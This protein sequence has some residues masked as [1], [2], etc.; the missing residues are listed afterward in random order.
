[1]DKTQFVYAIYSFQLKH[2]T[3]VSEF[4]GARTVAIL[5]MIRVHLTLNC[6]LQSNK[7][8]AMILNVLPN[9][10]IFLAYAVF[11]L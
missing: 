5:T 7:N 1:M 6:I 9:V 3:M 8:F 11:N 2:K 4:F 10:C